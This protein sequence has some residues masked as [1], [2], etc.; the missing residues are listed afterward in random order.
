M[1]V[2]IA[3][4]FSREILLGS[5]FYSF[6]Q[7]KSDFDILDFLASLKEKFLIGRENNLIFNRKINGEYYE[8]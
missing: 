5:N 2:D 6:F 1:T 3:L 4:D 8:K 7:K